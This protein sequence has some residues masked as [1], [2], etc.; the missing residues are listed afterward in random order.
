MG[1]PNFAAHWRQVTG[2]LGSPSS[3]LESEVRAVLQ[4]LFPQTVACQTLCQHGILESL[5]LGNSK[6]RRKIVVSR[7]QLGEPV[8]GQTLRR[9]GSPFGMAAFEEGL[10]VPHPLPGR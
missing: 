4:G 8:S 6:V 7:E 10:Q 1:I 3:C 9:R 5:K 2:V